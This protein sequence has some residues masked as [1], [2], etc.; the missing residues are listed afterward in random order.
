M[1]PGAGSLG[2]VDWELA[3]QWS[4][5]T[6]NSKSQGQVLV[7]SL[8][9]EVDAGTFDIFGVF[10]PYGDDE[11][12]TATRATATSSADAKHRITGGDGQITFDAFQL[13]N[14]P[15][16]VALGFEYRDE[17]YDTGFDEQTKAGA[18]GG[19]NV[20]TQDQSGARVVKSLFA[21]TVIPHL[22]D[23]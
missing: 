8:Q 17:D 18:F 10:G 20:D 1:R 5:Q 11:I 16:P 15:V 22:T 7:P 3:A 9:S 14:G 19:G 2:G 12:A 13:D 21:E 6:S 23:G 4:E